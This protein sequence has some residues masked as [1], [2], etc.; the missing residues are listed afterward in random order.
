MKIEVIDKN[1]K[2]SESFPK[3]MVFNGDGQTII[4]ATGINT[5]INAIIG[6][7][8]S[9]S[10]KDNIVGEYGNSWSTESFVDF[11]GSITLSND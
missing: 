2:P 7:V 3:L 8:I 6:V 10:N 11:E 1:E 9:S 5:I 4:L